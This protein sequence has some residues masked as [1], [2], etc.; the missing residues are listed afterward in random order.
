VTGGCGFI[1]TALTQFLLNKIEKTDEIVLVDTMKRHGQ[2]GID[3]IS[4]NPHVKIIKT[5]LSDP[6]GIHSIPGPV[7]RLYHLAAIVGVEPVGFNPIGVLRT[8]TMST[9]N[10]LDWF[11]ENKT[12]SARCI[13]SSSSEIYNGSFMTG[14]SLPIQTPEDVPAVISDLNN[15]R[16]SYALSKIWGEAYINYLAAKENILAAS[17]RYH[18]VYGPRMGYNH[19][20]PQIIMRILSRENPFRIV[21][22]EQTRSFCWVEDAVKATY[23]VMESKHLLPGMAVHVGNDAGEITI[24]SL[25]E[26]LFE[27]CGWTPAKAVEKPAPSGSVSRRCPSTERLHGLT[28]YSPDTSLEDGLIKTVAWYRENLS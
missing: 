9:M 18:N 14:F 8:N 22:G 17:V 25:Y 1:G 12:E 4:S 10:I 23:L 28:D 7:D 16:F 13:F 2:V 5:D 24:R 26:L 15:P 19:V 27:V 21:A 3:D 20:I 11:L 6:S